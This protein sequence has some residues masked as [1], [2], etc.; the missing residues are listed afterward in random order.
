M[1]NSATIAINWLACFQEIDRMKGCLCNICDTMPSDG[2][3]NGPDYQFLNAGLKLMDDI[4]RRMKDELLP[5][6][7]ANGYSEGIEAIYY[8]I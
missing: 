2:T 3:D 4:E 6:L 5:I 1:K 7:E 8:E